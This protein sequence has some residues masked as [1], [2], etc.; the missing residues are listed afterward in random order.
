MTYEVTQDDTAQALGSG[1]VPVL[2][3]PRLIAWLEAA[4]VEAARSRIAESQ[5]TVGTAV[6]VKHRRP[7]RVGGSITTTAKLTAGPDEKGRLSF[8]VSAVD[9]DGSTVADGEIDR[10]IVERMGAFGS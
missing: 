6:R 8:S 10:V 1:D 3:T 9:H 7:T 2:G 4:T 5:T